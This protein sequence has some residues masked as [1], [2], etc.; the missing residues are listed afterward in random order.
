VPQRQWHPVCCSR[1]CTAQFPAERE[2]LTGTVVAV[3]YEIGTLT[4]MNPSFEAELG[5]TQSESVTQSLPWFALHVR[6]QHE[7]S[8]AEY[9]RGCGYDL[10]LP[11]YKCRKRWSD[12]VKE[13]ESPLFPGYLFCRFNPMER[14]PILKTPGVIQIVGYNRQPV[15]VDEVEIRAVQTLMSAGLPNQPWPFLRAGDKVQI[16]SGPLRGV[17]GILTEFRGQ[18]RLIVSISLLQRAI[19][20]EIDSAL[21]TRLRA[22]DEERTERVYSQPRPMPVAI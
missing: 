6:T 21:V 20:V 16:E 17:S 13:V 10:I 3:A 7:K 8:V 22:A 18:H 15:S 5:V 12:R 11:V 14:L 19:A 1:G 4:I 9:L 2:W